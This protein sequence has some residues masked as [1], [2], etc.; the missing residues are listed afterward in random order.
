MKKTLLTLCLATLGPALHAQTAGTWL[1]QGGMA[2]ASPAVQSGHL[3]APSAA[4]VQMDVGTDTQP[5]LQLTHMLDDH[6]AVAV[7]LGRG[8][9]HALYGAGAIANVGQ[10]GTV[11]AQPFSVFGQYRFGEPQAR[12]RPYAML[13]LSYMR[14]H[15]ATGSATLN[16]INPANPP[17]GS[18][19]LSIESRWALSP[20]LG[21]VVQLD[22][23]WFVDASWSKT[24]LKTTATLSTGQTL[25]ATI[26]PSITTLGVGLRF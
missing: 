12:W 16:G 24:Y 6:W 26:N 15:D 2:H 21:L 14:F 18:T 23:R 9:T 1:V 3:S 10:I 11:S 17:G 25:G 19:G 13:G 5:M 7:P 8:F 22:E 20:G 4:G